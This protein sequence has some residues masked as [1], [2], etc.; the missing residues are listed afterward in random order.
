M[1]G[2]DVTH[3]CQLF[4]AALRLPGFRGFGAEAVNI[5]LQMCRLAAHFFG[6]CQIIRQ[7]FGTRALAG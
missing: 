2:G 7:A 4:D 5:T 3:A 6:H 1:C